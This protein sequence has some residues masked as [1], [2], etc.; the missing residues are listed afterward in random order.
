MVPADE[1]SIVPNKTVHFKVSLTRSYVSSL[2]VDVAD[3]FVYISSKNNG[4]NEDVALVQA[5]T[6]EM[7]FVRGV[8]AD[9]APG[10]QCF[11]CT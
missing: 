5:Y 4:L 7:A 3:C 11:H 2:Q 8:S 6:A 9:D 1:L 10:V